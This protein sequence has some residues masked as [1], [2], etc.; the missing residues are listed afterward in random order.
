MDDAGGSG[1]KKNMMFPKTPRKRRPR[2]PKL[3]KSPE[4]ALQQLA[5]EYLQVK[6][7]RYI[8]IPDGIYEHMTTCPRVRMDQRGALSQ[9]M[10]GQPDLII[11]LDDGRYICLELKRKGGRLH[12]SQRQWQ[13][14]Y[15]KKFYKVI[16]TIEDFVYIMSSV[17]NGGKLPV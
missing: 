14:G 13:S 12:L 6:G 2:R 9:Y 1:E 5:E 3:G 8:R 15:I 10:A 7:I 4:S 17:C 11:L 16:D